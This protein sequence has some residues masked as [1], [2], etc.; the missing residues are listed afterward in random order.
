MIR[1]TGRLAIPES[2]LV[3]TAS[4][5][6]GPGGQHVN[7]T[8]T[9]VALLFDLAASPRFTA[10]QKERIREKLGGRVNREGV[11][12]VS[13]QRHRSQ[14]ANRR[15]AMERFAMLLRQALAQQPERRPTAVPGGAKRR[16]LEEKRQ[17]GK[18]KFLRSPRSLDEA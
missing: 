12:R 8:S 13:A 5:S 14:A 15:W 10:A 17:R 4:R 9:R 2:E 7:K 16:R 18:S 6:S 11:L 3:F 1:V